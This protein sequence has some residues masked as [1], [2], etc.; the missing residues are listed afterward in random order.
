MQ[1]AEHVTQLDLFWV[2]MCSQPSSE[3][4][5][6]LADATIMSLQSSAPAWLAMALRELCSPCA[7][8][9]V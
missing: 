9:P 8:T 3:P 1:Q 6:P 5:P 4:G 2:P 7:V